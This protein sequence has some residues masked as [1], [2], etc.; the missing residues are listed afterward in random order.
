M[1]PGDEPGER[2]GRVLDGPAVDARVEVAGR[3][4]ERHLDVGQPAQTIG[5]TRDAG[6]E[7]RRVRDQHHVRGQF[8]AVGLDERHEVLG[9][10]FFFSLDEK[11]E[12]DGRAARRE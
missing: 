8:V 2:V 4:L 10:V 12:V 6:G 1:Q 7:E 9:A 3:P 5:E 11:D